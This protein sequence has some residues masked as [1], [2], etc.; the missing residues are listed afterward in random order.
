MNIQRIF[1]FFT[2]LIIALWVMFFSLKKVDVII[3]AGHEGLHSGNT[4]AQTKLY[5]EVDWNIK[6]ANR[7]AE[8]LRKRGISV[9]RMG[10]NTHLSRA[11]IA[12]AIH[13][14]GS[15]RICHSG[16]SVGYPN[17]NS[18]AFAQRWKRVYKKYFPFKWH[19]DNFTP[20]LRHYYGYYWIRADRFL[21]LELG[22]IT[23]AKQAKWLKPRL[24]KIAQMIADT[25][26]KELWT[27]K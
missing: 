15:K 25:I 24:D 18:K 4:G 3:Q 10:A 20:A 2:L 16:A 9:V 23:C 17:N 21:L 8:I 27:I 7:V 11:K 22:E 5:R 13:F 12:I 14:D 26:R 1:L 19:K 6:V